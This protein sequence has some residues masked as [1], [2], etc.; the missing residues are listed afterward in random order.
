MTDQHADYVARSE[1]DEACRYV[2]HYVEKSLALKAKVEALQDI[3]DAA[4][5]YVQHGQGSDYEALRELLNDG[6]PS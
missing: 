4:R 5:Q 1:Y 2:N 6:S 3:I